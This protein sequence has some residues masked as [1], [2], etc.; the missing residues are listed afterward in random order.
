V[1][2][3]DLVADQLAIAA[4]ARLLEIDLDQAG[5][6]RHLAAG[7][8]AVEV[9]LYAEDAENGF[10]P[11]TGRVTALSWPSGDGIRVDAGIAVGTEVGPRFDPLLAKI[12]AAGADRAEAFAQLERALDATVV[13]GLVTNLRFL[14]WLVREPAVLKGLLRTD[15]LD[16]IWPPDDWA[17][18]SA[19][20]D[21]AWVAAA[22]LLGGTGS[23]GS[24]TNNDAF[25]GAF[26]L[27]AA[28]VVRLASDDGSERSVA[29][30]LPSPSP[31]DAPV[32]AG[33][34]VDGTAFIDVGGRSVAFRLAAPPDVD[35]AA[36]AAA[37]HVRGS[38]PRTVEAPMPGS[39]VRVHVAVG[40]L[41]D[42]GAPLVTLE[43]MK[44]EH[45]VAAPGPGRVTEVAVRLG[46]QVGR[47]DQLATIDD[48]ALPLPVEEAR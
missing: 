15:T 9:R 1:T 10:L 24:P 11:A 47:G 12:V 25:A 7:G 16:R 14:R 39:V 28:P 30:P 45:V 44:M 43:A 35:R 29:V 46:A 33:V 3:R 22:G 42:G 36:R 34:L 8:H 32:I 40:D 17:D 31:A 26:R 41:V 37:G 5:I 18:R 48:A 20:P 23:G 6:D 2:E 38:G 19:I 27:N 21:E 13:L 4:G